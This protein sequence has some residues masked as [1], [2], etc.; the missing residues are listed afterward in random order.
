[1]EIVLTTNLAYFVLV[2][3]FLLA[4]FA[5]LSPGTGLFELG[6]LAALIFSAWAVLNL[7]INVWALLLLVLG[8]FPFLLAVKRTQKREYLLVSAL[9]YMVGSAYL[10]QGSEWWLPG[11]NPVL[12]AVVSLSAGGFLWAVAVKVLEAGTLGLSHDVS[13]LVGMVGETRT[14][15]H[16]EGSV[17][18]RGEMWSARSE[19]PIPAGRKVRITGREGLI[20]EIEPIDK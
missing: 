17:F 2:I 14:K 20:L 12:A 18:A 6:A 5:L 19:R 8:V 11:V 1:M 9:A 4:V 13:N 7:P 10:F 3:G 15:V 16:H